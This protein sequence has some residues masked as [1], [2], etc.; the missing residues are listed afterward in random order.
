MRAV[1]YAAGPTLLAIGLLDLPLY[2]GDMPSEIYLPA[3][4]IAIAPLLVLGGISLARTHQFS[5]LRGLLVMI[6]PVLLVL[7]EVLLRAALVL[8]TLPGLDVPDQPYYV[9]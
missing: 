9:P 8:R 4:A 5:L 7:L 3:A 2:L 6:W 1:G